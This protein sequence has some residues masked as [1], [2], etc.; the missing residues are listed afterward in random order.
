MSPLDQWSIYFEPHRKAILSELAK[1]RAQIDGPTAGL[2]DPAIRQ[3]VADELKHLAH[4][5]EA[6]A[7]QVVT[8]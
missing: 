2:T 1:I 6:L 8:H 5:F 3:R 4:E 7:G